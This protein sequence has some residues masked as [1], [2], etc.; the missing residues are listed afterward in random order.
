[1]NS[2]ILGNLSIDLSH[3]ICNRL[4]LFIHCSSH[5]STFSGGVA[6]KAGGCC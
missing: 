2:L 4:N 6:R 1:L 3:F 5:C